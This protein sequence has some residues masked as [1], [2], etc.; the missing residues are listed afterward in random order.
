MMGLGFLFML[1]LIALPV[2]LLVVLMSALIPF[3]ALDQ[4]CE[5]LKLLRTPANCKRLYSIRL[6][7]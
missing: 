7:H 1:A 6:A 4:T 3:L 2:I 5:V